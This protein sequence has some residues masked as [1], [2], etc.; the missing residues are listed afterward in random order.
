MITIN[1]L[2]CGTITITS[3]TPGPTAP[4]GKVLY[5]TAIGGEWLQADADI[6]DGEF[7]GFTNKGSAVEVILPSKDSSGNR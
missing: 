5:K 4:D 3:E 1:K 7:N 2:T 6:T